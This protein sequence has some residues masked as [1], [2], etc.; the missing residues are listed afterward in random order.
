MPRPRRMR[1]AYVNYI[2]DPQAVKAFVESHEVKGANLHDQISEFVRSNLKDWGDRPHLMVAHG[3]SGPHRAEVQGTE[4]KV[5]RFSMDL[6][7]PRQAHKKVERDVLEKRELFF[8][9]NERGQLVDVIRET[10]EA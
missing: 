10:L 1:R 2:A 6:L 9:V 5:F 8:S 4:R 3:L 7:G